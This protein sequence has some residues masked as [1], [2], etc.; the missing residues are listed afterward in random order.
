M[1]LKVDG[2]SRGAAA[3]ASLEN[4]PAEATNRRELFKKIAAI[5]LL[6]LGAL[7]FATGVA[8]FFGVTFGFTALP[9][10]AAAVGKVAAPIIYVVVGTVAAVAGVWLFPK[11]ESDEIDEN[12]VELKRSS[13]TKG[14]KAADAAEGSSQKKSSK[15]EKAEK[16]KA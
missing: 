3:V 14:K 13:E 10:L 15:T 5:A 2:N 8:A 7:A 16:K 6:A 1:S 11:K 12:E 9:L 4:T